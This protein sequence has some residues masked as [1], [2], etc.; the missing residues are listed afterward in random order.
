M[1]QLSTDQIVELHSQLISASGGTDGVRDL[2]L[3]ES[4]IA[5]AFGTYFGVDQ[6][7]TIEEKAARLCY[8]LVKNHGF[9]DGNKRIG[10]F[11]MLV[12][13]EINDIILDCTDKELVDLGVGVASSNLTYDDIL[14]FIK[15]KKPT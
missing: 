12:L 4:A 2:G 15:K 3:I 7:P 9:I 14:E 5:S 6:Y 13:L 8:S 10:I 1:K 11:A